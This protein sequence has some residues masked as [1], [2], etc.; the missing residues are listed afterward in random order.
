MAGFSRKWTL[1]SVFLALSLFVACGDDDSNF[2]KQDEEQEELSSGKGGSSSSKKTENSSPS[3]GAKFI[4]ESFVDERDDNEYK[5]ITINGHTWMAENLRYYAKDAVDTL[6]S[7]FYSYDEAVKACPGGWHLP[8]MNEWEE[9]FADV[10]SA[11]GTMGGYYLKSREGWEAYEDSIDGNGCDSLGFNVQPLGQFLVLLNETE[12]R[13]AGTNAYFWT[14]TLTNRG[15]T[16]SRYM[17]TFETRG[18]TPVFGSF[19]NKILAPVRCL[20]NDNTMA[21]SV[22]SCS[23]SNIGEMFV[24]HDQYYVCVKSGWENALMQEILNFE[25]GKCEASTSG[26]KGQFRDTVFVCHYNSKAKTAKWEKAEVE[27]ALGTCNSDNYEEIVF[28]LGVPYYCGVLWWE[29]ATA[30]EYLP[31]CEPTK[32]SDFETFRDTLY[33]CNGGSW[34]IPTETQIALGTC[35]R[36]RNG[37]LMTVGDS[38]FVCMEHFWR[39]LS[40]VDRELGLCKKNGAKGTYRGMEFVCDASRFLWKG[41]LQHDSK[42]YG[43]VAVDT[44]LWITDNITK[45][46]WN[47]GVSDS[48]NGE[49][50][51]PSGWIMP[52]K[53]EW[54]NMIDYVSNNGG[55]SSEFTIDSAKAIY[56]LNMV[57]EGDVYYWIPSQMQACS[58]N[59]MGLIRCRADAVEVKEGSAKVDNALVCAAGDCGANSGIRC[60][61]RP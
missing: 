22:G 3:Q 39:P 11:Y 46:R 58:D 19:G 13:Y 1:C 2:L 29:V 43:V 44:L 51:C 30:N 47:A 57:E 45:T 15:N 5:T 8:Y 17:V 16:I 56:G 12:Y 37:E 32:F 41:S 20:K 31:E 9:F 33:I 28:Y 54:T 40:I 18:R 14:N 60:V 10:E 42:T 36:D 7:Q 59:N 61:L 38:Q 34:K 23:S 50:Y 25:F 48:A 21:D 24:F 4:L 52:S 27:V 35:D 26:R 6:N 55:M 49:S 53:D